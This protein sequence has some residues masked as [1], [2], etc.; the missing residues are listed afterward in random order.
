MQTL[1]NLPNDDSKNDKEIGEKVSGNGLIIGAVLGACAV[2]FIFLLAFLGYKVFT[3]RKDHKKFQS[4]I[5]SPTRVSS[6]LQ[7]VTLLPIPP[8]SHHN[9]HPCHGR[10][11]SDRERP[12]ST[13]L[14]SHGDSR[15][16]PSYNETFLANGG[17]MVEV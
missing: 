6:P 8:S 1:D 2:L 4:T 17:A 7:Q 9:H 12:L 5:I 16:P 10:L 13:T 15:P 14:S 11:L 3:K